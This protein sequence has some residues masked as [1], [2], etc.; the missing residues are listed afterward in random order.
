MAAQRASRVGDSLRVISA[1]VGDYSALALSRGERRNFVV[2]APQLERTNRLQVLR[3][4][5][6]FAFTE[7]G[8]N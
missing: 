8:P 1:G 3:L 5:E 7:R 2:G 6:D 4:E